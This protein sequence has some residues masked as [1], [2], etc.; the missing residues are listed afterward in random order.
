GVCLLP[1]I[2]CRSTAEIAAAR[3]AERA[4]DA[5]ASALATQVSELQQE[6]DAQRRTAE[7]VNEQLTA[8]QQ[9]GKEREDAAARQRAS[10]QRAQADAQTLQQQVDTAEA[11]AERMRTALESERA[12][13]AAMAEALA[14]LRREIA[15]ATEDARA[16]LARDHTDRDA[17]ER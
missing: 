14:S 4:A 11:D 8:A 7:D 6:A 17:L 16:A 10:L 9:Q 3:D 12:E 13:R 15:G 1:T 5:R 2:A